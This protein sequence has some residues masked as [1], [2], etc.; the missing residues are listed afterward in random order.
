MKK[1][2][3]PFLRLAKRH[4]NYFCKLF[5]IT[6]LSK[7]QTQEVLNLQAKL[8]L[9]EPGENLLLAPVL[10]S[11][12]NEQLFKEN[13]I[14]AAPRYVWELN[15]EDGKIKLLPSGCICA[16]NKVL[17]LGFGNRAVVKDLLKRSFK[18]SP[19]QLRTTKILIAPWGHYWTG[20]Y[21][22]LFFVALNLYRIKSTMQPSEVAETIVCYPLFNTAFEREILLLI[23]F[24][25]ENIL[26]SRTHNVDF[27]TCLV[28]N[29]GSWFY[30]NRV[31]VLAF[32]TLIQHTTSFSAPTNNRIYIQR[33]GRRKV[34]NEKEL[35]LL[36]KKYDFS[37][38]EDVPRSFSDQLRLYHNASFIIGPHGASF[39]NILAC[40]AGTQLLELFSNTYVPEYFRYLAYILDLNY[41][42]YC[43]GAP[44]GNDHRFVQDDI[45]VNLEDLEQQLLHLL[46][47]EFSRLP[48]KASQ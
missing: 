5:N 20:Y 7:E 43:N 34:L 44:I 42:A 16:H 35:I 36:L 10:V 19:R 41:A 24:E 23:G 38:I 6:L 31:D 22:Y 33:T 48:S 46:P 13:S 28:G 4:S 9:S 37:V 3:L 40:R 27:K 30:P 26:D 1:V 25:P 8:L 2:L 45:I 11:A 14:S 39:A 17:D 29:N 15:N 12:T 21:D 18:R 47:Q 32:K